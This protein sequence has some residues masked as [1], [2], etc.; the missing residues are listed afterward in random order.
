MIAPR[1][2]ATPAAGA[3]AAGGV[4]FCAAA[5]TVASAARINEGR[6][7]LSTAMGQVGW[8]PRGES[9]REREN[10][11]PGPWFPQA[12]ATRALEGTAVRWRSQQA[13]LE[14]RAESRE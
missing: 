6:R 2:T 4:G 12:R 10:Q 11:W 7:R 13:Y 5:G 3:A 8:G 9:P 1:I 14:S